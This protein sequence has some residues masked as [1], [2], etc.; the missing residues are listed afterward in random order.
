MLTATGQVSARGRRDGGNVR[1]VARGIRLQDQAEISRLKALN[2][3]LFAALERA[4]ALVNAWTTLDQVSYET[5]MEMTD[6]VVP[7]CKAA[8]VKV[9]R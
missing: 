6:V 3:E 1:M 5:L 7:L 9:P 4:T 8:L 2:G